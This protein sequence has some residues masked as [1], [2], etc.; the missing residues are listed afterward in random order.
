MAYDL[1]IWN[2]KLEIGIGIEN[3]IWNQ[4]LGEGEVLG[5]VTRGGLSEFVPEVHLQI[6]GVA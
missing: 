3:Q 2:W 5:W 4:K 1:R 6:F